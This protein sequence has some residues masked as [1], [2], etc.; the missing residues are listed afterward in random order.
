MKPDIQRVLGATP[1]GLG[2]KRSDR[3]AATTCG[4]AAVVVH[5]APQQR[6]VVHYV[7]GFG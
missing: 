1:T 4:V 6:D 3:T 2:A 7:A 5:G